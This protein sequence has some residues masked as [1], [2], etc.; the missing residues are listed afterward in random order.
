MVPHTPL[1]IQMPFV[2]SD[3]HANRLAMQISQKLTTVC[4]Q[5]GFLHQKIGNN[6]DLHSIHMSEMYINPMRTANFSSNC[7][8]PE[9]IIRLHALN[10]CLKNWDSIYKF[11]KKIYITG[12]L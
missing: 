8:N 2:H 1:S 7:N 6:V 5:L 12:N 11:I 3:T 9:T 4:F 10:S